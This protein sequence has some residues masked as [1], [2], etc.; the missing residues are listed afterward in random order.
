MNRSLAFATMIL[1]AVALISHLSL[2]TAAEKAEEKTDAAGLPDAPTFTAMDTH[3]NEHSLKDFRGKYVVLEWI[4]D[5]CP[6]VK[7]FYKAG[8]MQE[9]Q[10]TY[11]DKGVVW[12]SIASSA[13]GKQGHYDADGWN[14]IIKDWNIKA[15][16]LLMDESGEIGRAYNAKTTPHIFIINPD[17]KLIY[18]GAIDSIRS[19]DT[20]DVEKAENYVQKVLDAALLKETRPYGCSVKY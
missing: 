3:G 1:A 4:N 15:T 10:K 6:F 19:A 11:A 9:L 14:K 7:K 8:K 5:G 13:P 2:T 12:L 18:H 17:G 20:A 16:A